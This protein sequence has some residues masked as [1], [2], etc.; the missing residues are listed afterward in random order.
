MSSLRTRNDLQPVTQPLQYRYQEDSE[1]Q[2]PDQE[3]RRREDQGLRKMHQDFCQE[4][5]RDQRHDVI[6]HPDDM[7]TAFKGGFKV[8]IYQILILPA[9]QKDRKSSQNPMKQFSLPPIPVSR[10]SKSPASLLHSFR[11]PHSFHFQT[12]TY[13]PWHA[14]SA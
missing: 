12:A 11:K 10:F 8:I 14:G 2:C 6:R 9:R 7:K 1:D 4:R 13:L 3:H 5:C